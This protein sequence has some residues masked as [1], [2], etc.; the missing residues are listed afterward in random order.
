MRNSIEMSEINAKYENALQ[1]L[2]FYKIVMV[3]KENALVQRNAY[4]YQRKNKELLK[5][6]F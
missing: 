1:K 3:H 4:N 5:K 6:R 2:E